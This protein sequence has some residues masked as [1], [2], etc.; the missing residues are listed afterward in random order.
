RNGDFEAGYLGGKVFT[1]NNAVSKDHP[2]TGSGG[3]L[4]F[5]SDLSYAGMYNPKGAC[6]YSIADQYGVGRVENPSC[7]PGGGGGTNTVYGQYGNDKGVTY[8]DHTLGTDKGFSLFIDFNDPSDNIVGKWKKVWG[9]KVDVYPNQNYYFSAWFTQYRLQSTAPTLRFR[10]EF[11]DAGGTVISNTTV[12][13]ASPTAGWTFQQFLGTI[14]SP[15]NAVK[16]NL[17]ID[18][19]PTGMAAQDDII[20]DD[21]SFINSCQN[22]AASNTY[23]IKFAK[24]SV[25]LCAEG[26]SYLAQVLK[27]TG[28]NLTTAAKVITWYRGAGATQTEITAWANQ[29]N[30]TITQADVYRVCVSDPANGCPISATIVA[31][32]AVAYLPPNVT[33]CSPASYTYDVG[34]NFPNSA[35]TIAWA[36]PSGAGSGRTYVANKSGVHTLTVTP[37]AGHPGCALS[38]SFTV[39]SNLPVAPTNLDFCDGGGTATT[40]TVGDGK[41]YKWSTS[42]TM[43][44][45]IGTGISVAWTPTAGT[46][47]DQTLYIQDASTSPLGSGGPS[48]ATVSTYEEAVHDLSFTTTSY[49]VLNSFKVR[50]SLWAA[51]CAGGATGAVTFTLTG[52]VTKSFVYNINCGSVTTV[53]A[54][55]ALPPGAYTLTANA[56][57]GFATGGTASIGAGVVNI[58]LPAKSSFSD[59]TFSSA[60]A[61]DPLP[62]VIK[63]KSCCS[64][65]TDVPSIDRT[66]SVLNICTP[67]KGTIVSKGG[68]TSTLEYK[69]Q[70]SHD[71]GTTWTDTLASS[72]VGATGKV[73]LANITGAGLYRLVVALPGNL[74]KS[75]VKTDTASVVVKALPKNITVTVAPNQASFCKGVAHTLTASATAGSTFQWKYDGTGT[76]TTTSGLT[77]VGSHKYKVI[78]TLNGCVDSSALK[79]ITVTATDSA[80]ILP[81]GPFCSSDPSYNLKL[82]D[83]S[84]SGGTWSGSGVTNTSSGVFN[85]GSLSNGT[86]VVKY[87]TAGACP[88]KDSITIAISNSTVLS[89]TSTKSTYCHNA[90]K[91][92]IEVNPT[93]GLFWTSSGKGITDVNFGYYDPKLANIGND[94]IWYGK[95]GSCGDT[96][97]KAIT[98]TAV[99]TA[100]ITLG[101]GPFCQ[102]EGIITL[103]KETASS[104]G[105]WS[106]TGIT[107]GAA[108][109]FDPSVGAGS[110]LITYKTSGSCPV[111]DT[112]TIKV[113]KQKIA[114]ILTA[115]TALCKNASSKQIRLSTNSTSGGTWVSL[116]TPGL[117]S[118]TGLFTASA[119][120]VYKVYYGLIGSTLSCSAVDSVII[121]VGAG[122]TAKITLGQGPFCL[123]DPVQNLKIESASSV[124]TWSGVG[125]TSAATGSFNPATAGV[126]AHL[127]TYKTSGACFA[128]DTLT[129]NVVNQMVANILPTVVSLCED[130]ALYQISK[131]VNSTP[132]GLWFSVPTG[133]VNANGQFNAKA[134][135]AGTTYR[136]YYVVA[137]ATLTCSAADSVDIT[138]V[139]REE[140]SITTG[141]TLSLCSFDA[142]VQLATLNSGG[143][144][145]GTGVDA[146][147]MFD[148][149]KATAGGPYSV[150]YKINGTTGQCPDEDTIMVTVKAPSDASIK[151]AG[152]F[153]ENLPTQQITPTLTGGTF[154]GLGISANGV[155]NPSTAGAGTHWIKYTQGGQCP[156]SDSIQIKVDA[157]P[158][159]IIS[160]DVLGGCVPVTINFADSSTADVATAHWDF[161]DGSTKDLSTADASTSHQFTTAG[162]AINVTLSVVFVNGCK[163]NTSQKVTVTEVPKPDFTFDPVPAS[164]N[165]PQITFVNKST[166]STSYF[167]NF[168][169]TAL[170]DTSVNTDEVVVFDAPNG[171]TVM[172]TLIA[173]NAVCMDSIKKLVYIKDV[174]TLFAA[175]AFTPNGDG[176][177]DLFFPNGKNLICDECNNYE[178]L[179]FNRW[180]EVIFKSNTPYDPWNGKRANTL[181]DAEID[182]YVW[183]LTYT[184]SFTGKSGVKTGHVTLLR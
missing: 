112:A 66:N 71:A 17:Y 36:G 144:W 110:Y 42:S 24:D 62:V 79:T 14:I 57:L 147:G 89:I 78:A 28:G 126:G 137:G 164:S 163:D 92:T 76:S 80:K 51:P 171:D 182:V 84:T 39:T 107:S 4:D 48:A 19:D 31:Y 77:T 7:D 70:V 100:K 81:A 59:L 15:V 91:D 146:S 102:T 18:A 30:P 37:G 125:I 38:K 167:W 115:D 98:I 69:W 148:P 44:P 124:G 158:S 119:V 122:D 114:N 1:D 74:A 75:C 54:D 93:G 132:G 176:N 174:F 64:A 139:K 11:L 184:N 140:A 113:E 3:L 118:N 41:S 165:N 96:A 2:A 94:T 50:T 156:N 179:I 67:N 152:P 135:A 157:V 160:P 29:V 128:Q 26:G 108:G 105:T 13:S 106:G 10:V 166:N 172:V 65:P 134:A 82:T 101:Q 23:S 87:T 49:T 32:E 149:A 116:P 86:Y 145:S 104:A 159:A 25:N 168:G 52:P 95:A 154:S 8:K 169:A 72:V 103:K 130:T 173:K 46:T 68:L 53:A 33:L 136:I 117:V 143:V 153:C 183:R 35:M 40:L 5:S 9:Q 170:P 178:F 21:I 85:P 61:C 83:G 60:N 127:I 129:I 34:Y 141:S 12:G 180:G 120:G 43:T 73:T 16:A 88:N 151:A 155:F 90:S 45:L 138:V 22:I 97:F 131:S 161:G 111:Q 47:G 56:S 99:D 20:I 150:R 133:V 142:A 123:G 109:T 63:A 177:N 175:N 58:T 181:R 55:V 162:E 27:T 121:T 6:K